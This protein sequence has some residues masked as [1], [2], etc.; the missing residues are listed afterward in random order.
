MIEAKVPRDIRN[1]EVKMVGPLTTRQVILFLAAVVLDA[2]AYFFVLKPMQV[3]TDVLVYLIIFLDVPIMAFSYKPYGIKMEDFIRMTME[4][5]V[6]APRDR[7]AE[8]VIHEKEEK[9]SHAKKKGKKK[10]IKDPGTVYSI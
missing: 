8:C 9:E 5:V 4:R 3:P 10:R 6:M 1:Y 7:K 2:I